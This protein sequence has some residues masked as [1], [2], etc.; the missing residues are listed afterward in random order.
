[1]RRIAKWGA[2]VLG[3]LIVGAV[4]FFAVFDWN[5]LKGPL[6]NAISE[7]LG[8]RFSISGDLDVRLSL[9]PLISMKNVRLANE[10]WGSEPHMVQINLLQLRVS[11]LALLSGSTV[12]RELVIRQPDVLLE[13]NA[14]GETNWTF[15]QQEP[16]EKTILP[17]IE[18]L[19]INQGRIRYKSAEDKGLQFLSIVDKLTGH[20]PASQPLS[21]VA[22]GQ[23]ESL[24]YRI[25]VRGESSDNLMGV[26]NNIQAGREGATSENSWAVNQLEFELGKTIISGN[27]RFGTNNNKPFFNARLSS[28]YLD[29]DQLVTLVKAEVRDDP[30][31]KAVPKETFDLEALTSINASVNFKANKIAYSKVPLKTAQVRVVLREGVLLVEPITLGIAAGNIKGGFS[32]T[33]PENPPQAKALFK[34]NAIRLGQFTKK[35]E[36]TDASSGRVFGHIEIKGSGNS[37]A[38][39]VATSSGEIILIMSSGRLDYLFIEGLGLDIAEALGI[40]LTEGNE[41]SKVDCAVGI[42]NIL[43][44]V[45]TVKTF[46]I[47]T[48][49]SNITVEGQVNFKQEKFALKF[50]AHPK[51]FSPL[52][53]R[54]PILLQGTFKKPDIKPEKKGLIAKGAAAI[55]LGFLLSPLA[56]II[57]LMEP[58]LASEKNCQALFN[59]AVAAKK[60]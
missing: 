18:S 45:M 28:N 26:I 58:G 21:L 3:S 39:L 19:I 60:R 47:D 46:V 34:I 57:P 11:L 22:N 35:S 41:A 5:R 43:D 16:K 8:R 53:L 7:Q 17:S 6:Q 31:A 56:A 12:V 13:K 51:D 44:G 42:M 37:A 36:V 50:A 48:N 38:K 24:P 32:Y 49:D 30:G 33:I 20:L 15:K 25:T 9:N 29:V 59:R 55:G 2:I 14:I 54:T 1:M 40:I 10:P 52:S 23:F 27:A 4:L